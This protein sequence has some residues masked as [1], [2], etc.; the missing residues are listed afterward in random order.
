MVTLWDVNEGDATLLVHEGSNTT[1][2]AF[3][4]KF[5]IKDKSN[6]YKLSSDAE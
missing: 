5:G 3:G 6:W 4:Q 2:K 1:H